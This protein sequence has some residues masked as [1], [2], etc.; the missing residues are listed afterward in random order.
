[1]AKTLKQLNT[2]MRDSKTYAQTKALYSYL[3]VRADNKTGLSYP[4]KEQIIKEINLTETMYK[5]CLS[6]LINKGYIKESI[7]D[8]VDKDNRSYQITAYDLNDYDTYHQQQ[9]NIK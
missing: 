9:L 4:P 7:I 5:Q 8:K 2:V 6:V 3:W 1:M